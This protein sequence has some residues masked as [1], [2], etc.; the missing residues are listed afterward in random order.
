V[1]RPARTHQWNGDEFVGDFRASPV[2]ADRLLRG[3]KDALEGDARQRG[4]PILAP[5][6]AVRGGRLREFHF[7]YVVG[8]SAGRVEAELRAQDSAEFPF[9]LRLSLEERVK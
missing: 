9:R 8:G 7:G 5:G 4:V 3:L 1:V 2:V 6:E